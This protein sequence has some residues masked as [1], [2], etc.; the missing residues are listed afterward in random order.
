MSSLSIN[1]CSSWPPRTSQQDAQLAQRPRGNRWGISIGCFLLFSF[2]QLGFAQLVQPI[3]D[4]RPAKSA[5][6]Q[7]P[8]TAH[9]MTPQQNASTNQADD[10]NFNQV[11]QLPTVPNSLRTGSLQPN[12]GTT[13][14]QSNS[15]INRANSGQQD[16][17]QNLSPS[18]TTTKPQL[19][20]PPGGFQAP[21]R[22]DFGAVQ[23]LPTAVQSRPQG[24]LFGKMNTESQEPAVNH[25]NA[26]DS[27]STAAAPAVHFQDQGQSNSPVNSGIQQATFAPQI[28]D[29]LANGVTDP[30]IPSN[31]LQLGQSP[32]APPS[33]VNQEAELNAIEKKY[34]KWWRDSLM[35]AEV[36]GEFLEVYQILQIVPRDA[37]PAVLSTY[38]Q[39]AEAIVRWQVQ[40]ESQQWWK[41]ATAQNTS[42]YVTSM[43]NA[44]AK[45]V[46][47]AEIAVRHWQSQF[48][49]QTRNYG[50]PSLVR[51]ADGP[52]IG[53]YN[54][55]ISEFQGGLPEQFSSLA[56][57]IDNQW[58][59]IIDDDT[60]ISW[61]SSQWNS[62]R[63]NGSAENMAAAFQL[64]QRALLILAGHV[65]E[66]N[67]SIAKYALNVSGY[68][69]STEQ[70]IA[71]LLRQPIIGGQVMDIASDPLF[72]Q[73][74]G[75]PAGLSSD[76]MNESGIAQVSYTDMNGNPIPDP[77]QN[78]GYNAF[79]NSAP[80]DAPMLNAQMQDIPMQGV[81][82]Q[83]VQ[84]ANGAAL[85]N[86]G[87][88]GT[89]SMPVN[90][91]TYPANAYNTIRNQG[92]R[93]PASRAIPSNAG[94]WQ[95]AQN[96]AATRR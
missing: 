63:Y 78:M 7:Q 30:E 4:L 70:R 37:Q 52:F 80:L 35:S 14:T 95:A 85:N 50:L 79:G 75:F 26:T 47:L 71:M 8:L 1:L 49:T 65:S 67:Q 16:S 46:K 10:S 6:A 17:A 62:S 38:W 64:Q 72:Q 81:P 96:A 12:P 83:A 25:A 42:P 28:R 39:L 56:T 18:N 31:L 21:G 36:E 20:G 59:T 3:N 60:A 94:A 74:N 61:A 41:E 40:I 44:I 88:I 51:P 34:G 73:H 24:D 57:E 15:A 2:P 55:R 13:A 22:L 54:T 77:Y 87:Q 66:Y 86:S 84:V 27:P 48:A 82:M 23:P 9:A 89:T 68:N 11:P 29:G 19:P 32:A 33:S 91:N 45:E 69:K 90:Q 92:L 5:T 93:V 58:K 53:P 43:S 76:L